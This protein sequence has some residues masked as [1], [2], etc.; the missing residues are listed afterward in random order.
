[1]E[2][3]LKGVFN[4]FWIL[5]VGISSV[6]YNA[7][8]GVAC[9]ITI[10]G[11][12]FGL[13]YFKFLPLVFA[14]A[15][16]V[17]VTKFGKHPIMNTLWLLFGGFETFLVYL[18]LSGVLSITIIGIPLAKQLFKI[19]KFNLAP[20]GAE[21]INENEYSRYGDTVHDMNLLI[22]R[23][24]ADP[25]RDVGYLTATEY[26]AQYKDEYKRSRKKDSLILSGTILFVG[27]TLSVLT[28]LIVSKFFPNSYTIQLICLALPFVL[29]IVLF[30]LFVEKNRAKSFFKY[31]KDLEPYYMD[32]VRLTKREYKLYLKNFYI[33]TGLMDEREVALFEKQS[34]TGGIFLIIFA[35]IIAAI[36]AYFVFVL[37]IKF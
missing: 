3:F 27:E 2:K 7:V 6:I 9:M 37:H 13:Q 31:F 30:I 28:L 24:I 16:K 26:V 22:H 25:N 34:K 18:I 21:V 19:A 33:E 10:I 17:V 15:G 4:F 36:V 32:D 11:I 35:L 29:V 12:P 1:M 23:V 20:F 14:P 5:I 8:V